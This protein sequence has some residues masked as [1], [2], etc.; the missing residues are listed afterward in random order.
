MRRECVRVRVDS[1]RIAAESVPGV[2]SRESGF[3]E[4]RRRKCTGSVASQL[5]LKLPLT[6]IE[7]PNALTERR[8]VPEDVLAQRT[9]CFVVV[10]VLAHYVTFLPIILRPRIFMIYEGATTL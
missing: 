9:S 2:R 3:C 6:S 5:E 1:V 10:P 4:D 7:I 8:L